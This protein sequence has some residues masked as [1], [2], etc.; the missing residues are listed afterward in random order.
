LD[1]IQNS[2]R[3]GAHNIRLEIVESDQ[4]DSLVIKIVDNGSG[5]DKETLAIVD[6]PYTTSR[7]TRKIGMGI[8]LLKYHAELT[9]GSLKIASKK[10]KGTEV[11]AEFR[12]DHI[13]RQPMGD[14]CGVIKILLMAEKNI[15]FEYY[16]AT[17]RGN[18]EFKSQDAK[19]ILEIEDFSDFKLAKEIYNLL[20]ENLLE[21]GAEIT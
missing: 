17:D 7:T 19:S 20:K 5:M 6:D 11:V 16:H 1:I 9:G 13:D 10:G 8:P 18:Y 3:A 2:I 21:I 15:D 14:I 12:K 4:S